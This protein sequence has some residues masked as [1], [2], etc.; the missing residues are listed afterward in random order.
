MGLLRYA[1]QGGNPV[2][3][4]RRGLIAGLQSCFLRR[5]VFQGDFLILGSI[6]LCRKAVPRYPGEPAVEFEL[7]NSF[8]NKADSG[9]A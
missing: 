8:F 9:R 1:G 3:E 4:T 7:V 5:L 6:F 2:G